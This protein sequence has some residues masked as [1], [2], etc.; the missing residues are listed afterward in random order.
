MSKRRYLRW[1]K[2]PNIKQDPV[3]LKRNGF[4]LLVC[5]T[6]GALQLCKK[7]YSEIIWENKLAAQISF[8]S[9]HSHVDHF[10]KWGHA[11]DMKRY[12]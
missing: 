7:S 10:Q 12:E 8:N 1:Y 9:L 2:S 5:D 3:G 4:F 6:V 11:E